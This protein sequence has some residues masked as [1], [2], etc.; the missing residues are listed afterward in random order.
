M[1]V[2]SHALYLHRV[3][4]IQFDVG[5]FTNL[6]QDHLDFHHTM[7]EY[8]R[9]KALLFRQSR[10]GLVNADD[11]WAG[12]L[13]E[14]A[15]CPIHTYAVRG[16]AELEARDVDLEIDHVA[17]TARWQGQETACRLGIPGAFSV[18]NALGALGVALT[19]E[20]VAESRRA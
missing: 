5:L 15:T 3:A 19:A 20:A 1:E 8:G 11:P 9:A 6:T 7:E 14:G 16:E 2:S 13:M 4:G 10:V 18:Y 12:L 17:F